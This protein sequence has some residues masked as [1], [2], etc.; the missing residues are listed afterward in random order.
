MRSYYVLTLLVGLPQCVTYVDFVKCFMPNLHAKRKWYRSAADALF[1]W[2]KHTHASV[3]QS[4]LLSTHK[5]PPYFH[6]NPVP[7]R[8]TSTGLKVLR[9]YS[10]P[11]NSLCAIIIFHIFALHSPSTSPRQIGRDPM[12]KLEHV[13]TSEA[14]HELNFL[15]TTR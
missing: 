8:S 2:D 7:G 6:L 3:H 9:I 5:S 15:R 14:R 10:L 1:Q 12:V 4:S 13:P 11:I